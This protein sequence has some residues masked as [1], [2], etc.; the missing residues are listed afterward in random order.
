MGKLQRLANKRAIRSLAKS[1]SSRHPN[2]PKREK[3]VGSNLMPGK[4][5]A[6]A[7]I[8]WTIS[9]GAFW[10]CCWC[11]TPSGVSGAGP[12]LSG[13]ASRAAE[14]S[15]GGMMGSAFSDVCVQAAVLTINIQASTA[16]RVHSDILYT[17]ST[18]PESRARL[19]HQSDGRRR[20]Q[21]PAS[22]FLPDGVHE[23]GLHMSNRM[24]DPASSLPPSE[25]HPTPRRLPQ[26]AFPAHHAS[27]TPVL[28]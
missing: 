9:N 15:S 13:A 21:A 23:I 10:L 18:K 25:T 7:V 11:G 3:G 20:T 26:P 24:P 4:G 19:L 16:M 6:D 27:P 2:D 22:G 28:T 1:G 14:I 8:A 5:M 12:S 17:T